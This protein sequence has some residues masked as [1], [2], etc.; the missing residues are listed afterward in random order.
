M[1]G[2]PEFKLQYI[3][4]TNENAVEVGAV[5]LQ[6]Q[7]AEER[8]KAYYSKTLDQRKH[9]YCITRQELLAVVKAAKDFRPYLY[10]T[11]FKLRTYHASLRWLCRRHKP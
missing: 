3:L 4:D 8:V 6:I 2:Y 5:L 9:N 1:L 10:G 11:K 7:E